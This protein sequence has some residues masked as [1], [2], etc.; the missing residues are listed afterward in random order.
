M[1]L[2]IAVQP[3]LAI[4]GTRA[5]DRF[6]ADPCLLSCGAWPDPGRHCDRP[7]NLYAGDSFSERRLLTRRFV[8]HCT[9]PALLLPRTKNR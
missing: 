8:T 4:Y 6:V 5:I 3:I 9:S 2:R 7:F 1:L